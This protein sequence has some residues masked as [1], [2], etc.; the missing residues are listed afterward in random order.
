[1]VGVYARARGLGLKPVLLESLGA[2]TPFG[3]LSL[4]GLGPR[5]RLEVW[6]GRLYLDGRRV[7][8][9]LDLFAHL[10]KGLGRGFFP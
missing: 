1:M 2:R 5:H 8:S 10:Q 6:E 9:A 3:R 4:L 7:G